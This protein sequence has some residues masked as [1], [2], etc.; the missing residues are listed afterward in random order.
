MTDPTVLPVLEKLN[1]GVNNESIII[2]PYI[3][4]DSINFKGNGFRKVYS[5]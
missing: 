4:L 5:R 3:V 1:S 2:Y